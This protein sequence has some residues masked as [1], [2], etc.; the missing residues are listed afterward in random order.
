MKPEELRRLEQ[1]DLIKL[2]DSGQ[3]VPASS[4]DKIR[5]EEHEKD[6][7]IL[8]SRLEQT[9][10]AL[11]AIS[12][13]LNQYKGKIKS[14]QLIPIQD[15]RPDN[16]QV[17]DTISQHGYCI[18]SNQQI[19]QYNAESNELA[20]IKACGDPEVIRILKKIETDAKLMRKLL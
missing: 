9:S 5:R 12:D 16:S 6:I 18:V 4:L 15:I 10:T 20:H 17:V 14:G 19:K 3:L 7:N 11:E 2:I 13:E 8:N 1:P